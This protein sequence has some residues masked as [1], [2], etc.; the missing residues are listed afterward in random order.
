M[1]YTLAIGDRTYSSWSLRGWLLFAAFDIPFTERR[2]QMLTP[3]FAEMLKDFGLAKTVPALLVDD[4][5]AVTDSLAIVETL[6]ELEP[7]AGHYPSDPADRAMARNLVSEMHSGF[8]ALR[9]A[10]PMNVAHAWAGFV[11]DEAVLADL[12]RLETLWAAARAPGRDGPW[13]FGQYT[14]ADAFF[15]P[16]A[17]RIAGYG[18][19]VGADAMAYVDAH[20]A[21]GPFRRWRAMGIAQNRVMERYVLPFDQAPWPGPA[22]LPAEAVTGMTPINATCP[23]SGDPVRED[24]LARINGTVIGYCNPFCRDKSVADPEAWPQTMALLAP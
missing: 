12:A 4:T 19:P 23:Y 3:G 5:Y 21:H 22:R 16:V 6:A 11:P 15:A 20:L 17:A 10:C 1:T 8:T 9:G 7:D 14:A 2:A 13:L 18:L 24:S